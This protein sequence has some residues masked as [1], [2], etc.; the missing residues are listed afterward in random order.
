MKLTK[1]QSK[2]HEEACRLLE[3]DGLSLDERWFVIENWHEGAT[4]NTGVL[5]AYFTP[6]DLA[7]DFAI[8]VV[9]GRIVDLCAGI[10][11]LAFIC[12]H[13]RYW[14]RAPRIVC[15]EI[16]PG[17]VEVGKKILPE[18]DWICADVFDAWQTVGRFDTAISNPPYGRIKAGGRAPRYGGSLF[19]YKLV[20]LAAHIADYGTFLLP[21]NSAG[22]RYSGR[23]FY[24]RY[25]NDEYRRFES[26]TG[27]ALEVGCGV[28]TSIYADD[29]RGVKP[30]CEVV[31]CDFGNAQPALRS[32]TTGQFC[33]AV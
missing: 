17:Y 14:D 1:Q 22:F 32:A 23:Q 19:E 21:Q 11:T 24:D 25:E 13:T 3:K 10:G 28:D 26:D 20:D 15:I 29:W 16:N 6:L 7:R 4:H 2:R 8:D 30:T 18:A 9:G 5:G 33:L 31:C 27:L 12:L